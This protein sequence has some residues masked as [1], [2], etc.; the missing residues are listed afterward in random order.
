MEAV[1]A[2]RFGV[3]LLLAVV[4]CAR[5]PRPGTLAFLSPLLAQAR[6]LRPDGLPRRRA[7]GG[8]AT[9]APVHLH[10]AR[11]TRLRLHLPAVR[12]CWSCCRTSRWCR[13]RP[14]WSSLTAAVRRRW[15]CRDHLVARRPVG[16]PARLAA[17]V[18]RRR[19]RSR[20]C[21]PLE[22]VRETLGWGQIN[23]FLVA[24]VLADLGRAATR[25]AVGRRGHRAGHRDQADAG[26]VR[27]LPG[28][29]RGRLAGRRSWPAATF[30]GRDPGRLRHS[31]R[32]R[33][34]GTGPRTLLGDR[35]VGHV[36]RTANQS[37]L[38]VLARLADPGRRPARSGL[39]LRRRGAGRSASPGPVRPYRC[40]DELAG[41]TLVGLTGVPGQPD[42]LDPPPVLGRSPRCSC[43]STSPPAH[44]STGAHRGGCG[45]RPDGRAGPRSAS[46]PWWSADR[47]PRS[48]W[49]GSST[50]PP[51]A[52]PTPAWATVLGQERLPADA[53]S[54]LVVAL[55]PGQGVTCRSAND[56][57]TSTCRI[58]SSMTSE[59][60][61][62]SK[63]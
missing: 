23:L 47:V 8:S 53:W 17:L 32:R 63:R 9:A 61:P 55:L 26:P 3:R 57:A 18:R 37:L 6:L 20:W 40:G 46:P 38:G 59:P 60:W 2:R 49:S 29:R 62:A 27:R 52:P 28:A 16:R 33:R 31:I 56:S 22:P 45:D 50:P 12:R 51:P 44:R 15:C 1:P 36:D 48:R 25:V 7:A 21:S 34:C 5:R 30:L 42:L 19:S 24:L 58:V 4:C 10:P 13:C 35:R 14:P 39:V 43:S 54:A 41:F 11:H